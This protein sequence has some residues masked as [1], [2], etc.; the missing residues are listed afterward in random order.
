MGNHKLQGPVG[1][2]QE[3][4]DRDDVETLPRPYRDVGATATCVDRVYM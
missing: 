1:N 3:I 2:F 4:A